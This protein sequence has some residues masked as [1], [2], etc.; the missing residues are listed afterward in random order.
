MR[1]LA[2]GEW[3]A[4][5]GRL[6]SVGPSP[7]SS[8]PP[9]CPFPSLATRSQLCTRAAPPNAESE[10]CAGEC[11]AAVRSV[12][13]SPP[14]DNQSSIRNQTDRQSPSLPYLLCPGVIA[15]RSRAGCDKETLAGRWSLVAG[16][17]WLESPYV[18]V[19]CINSHE[20]VWLHFAGRVQAEK[21]DVWR[22]TLASNLLPTLPHLR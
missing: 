1:W 21:S 14:L 8:A 3:V 5:P 6:F 18:P 9:P 15:S 7:P 11:L 19:P 13:R 22:C 16:L 12:P 4:G 20:L 2:G 10:R 17:C